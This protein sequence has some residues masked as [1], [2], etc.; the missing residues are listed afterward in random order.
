M[1]DTDLLWHYFSALLTLI[2][3]K[4]IISF[5]GWRFGGWG[6][7]LIV[8]GSALQEQKPWWL[9]VASF[10]GLFTQAYFIWAC[11]QI[12]WLLFKPVFL[13]QF[14]VKDPKM[15]VSYNSWYN[16]GGGG[17]TM[18]DGNH[19]QRLMGGLQFR[20]RLCTPSVLAHMRKSLTCHHYY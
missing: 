20:P 19:R 2:F 4:S 10:W 11:L 14:H 12:V 15:K 16:A 8:L 9:R 13:K 5:H 7:S 3:R 6:G 1:F 18:L 17:K